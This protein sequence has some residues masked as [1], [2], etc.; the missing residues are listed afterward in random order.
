M[1]LK[2]KKRL[3]LAKG[4]V[5]RIRREGNIP[6]VLYSQ[7]KPGD[8]IEVSGAQYAAISRKLQ[9]GHLPN[10]VFELTNEEGTQCKAVVK[11]IQYNPTT[12]QVLHLDFV[13]LIDDVPVNVKVPI[14][15]VGA[16]ECPGVKLG[17]V[18]RQVIR[19]VPVRC[20]PKDIPSEF[21]LDVSHMVMSQSRRLDGIELPKGV[22]ALCNMSEVAAVIAKR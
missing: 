11:D 15:Y 4:E 13:Q 14:K 5:N 16:A 10:T 9:R 7:G 1:E 22:R 20:L 18:L 2:I 17:G 6:A 8:N 21:P 12:Y 3:S 19:H